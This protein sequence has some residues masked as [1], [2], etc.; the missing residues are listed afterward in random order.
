MHT[1]LPN[2]DQTGR[3]ERARNVAWIAAGAAIAGILVALGS[4]PATEHSHAG[5]RL[6]EQ[7]APAVPQQL[8]ALGAD[9]NWDAIPVA[10]DPGPAAIAAYDH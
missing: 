3:R 4:T 9:V 8:T 5:A 1:D 7:S 6:I 10:A 2:R